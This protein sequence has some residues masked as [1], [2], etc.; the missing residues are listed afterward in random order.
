MF[1]FVLAAAASSNLLFEFDSTSFFFF[2]AFRRHPPSPC[3]KVLG[4]V[5]DTD[6]TV[7]VQLGGERLKR[8][9]IGRGQGRRPLLPSD[10]GAVE[11]GV[12]GGAGAVRLDHGDLGGVL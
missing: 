8:R 9:P 7:S 1:Q 6:D 10:G 2:F 12:V 4:S 11:V 5:H 3:G